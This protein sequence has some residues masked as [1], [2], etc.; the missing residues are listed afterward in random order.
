MKEI[1]NERFFLLGWNVEQEIYH[2]GLIEALNTRS[3]LSVLKNF[4]KSKICSA[5]LIV[6]I[7]NSFTLYS[8]IKNKVSKK[9]FLETLEKAK[10]FLVTENSIEKD[11]EEIEQSE[12]DIG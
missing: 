7:K 4:I 6:P 11:L 10:E 12:N 5:L 8:S 9:D 2:P 1:I 3:E